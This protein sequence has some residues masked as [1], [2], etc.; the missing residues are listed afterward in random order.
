M[1]DE[2]KPSQ[3]PKEAVRRAMRISD[4]RDVIR[5]ESLMGDLERAHAQHNPPDSQ[6]ASD[7][8]WTGQV[9]EFI[10]LG[11]ILVPPGLLGEAFLKSETINWAAMAAIFVGYWT[12]GAFVLLIGKKWQQWKPNYGVIAPVIER[13]ARN[14]W[15]WLLLLIVFAFGPTLLVGLLST[16][17]EAAR[18]D[19]SH[20][21][22]V[23]ATPTTEA[24][25]AKTP[26]LG[27]DDAKRWQWAHSLFRATVGNNN[28]RVTS[29]SAMIWQKPESKSAA[30]FWNESMYLFYLADWG[31][32]GGSTQKSFFPDGI[33]ILSGSDH[34]DAFN[35]GLHL[36][37]WLQSIGVKAVDFQAKQTTPDL[38]ECKNECVEIVVGDVT[39]R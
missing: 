35:C 30:A 36:K 25:S 23:P 32:G 26:F 9:L 39:V 2:E 37:E 17:R 34:G 14:I 20:Q 24:P 38:I 31:V 4:E 3:T 6:A 5:D 33:T 28:R 1:S 15:V 27:L 29:C 12:V 18:N 22:T 8:G 7:A 21:N 11:F 16:P 19:A 13:G 10:G